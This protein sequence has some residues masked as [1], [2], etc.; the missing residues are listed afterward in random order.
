MAVPLAFQ[1]L[2]AYHGISFLIDHYTTLHL[3]SIDDTVDDLIA[4][5]KRN[6]GTLA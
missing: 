5:C 1:Y 2:D 3:Q 6:G 4:Y